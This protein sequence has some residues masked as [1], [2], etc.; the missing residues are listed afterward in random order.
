[1]SLETGSENK[2][3]TEGSQTVECRRGEPFRIGRAPDRS[4][5]VIPG[6]NFIFWSAHFAGE[7]R[8]SRLARRLR[9]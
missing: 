8:P 6:D 3:W 1:M 4:Q 9:E 2:N 5:L 7:Y